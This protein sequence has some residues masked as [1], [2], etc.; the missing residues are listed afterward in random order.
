MGLP[1]PTS[2]SAVSGSGESE[3]RRLINQAGEFNDHR[4]GPEAALAFACGR[5]EAD[6]AAVIGREPRDVRI[7]CDLFTLERR[8]GNEGGVFSVDDQRRHLDLLDERPGA[9]PTVIMC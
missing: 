4:L 2:A 6:M 5:D 1:I 3:L 9:G 8:E 7:S